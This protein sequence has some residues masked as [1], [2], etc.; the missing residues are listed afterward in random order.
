MFAYTQITQN[1][2]G[3]NN[4]FWCLLHLLRYTTSGCRKLY[5]QACLLLCMVDIDY[6]GA[7]A[8]ESYDEWVA[9]GDYRMST[10]QEARDMIEEI[11]ERFQSSGLL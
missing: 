6:I 3:L 11:I 9:D 8:E 2:H 1:V 4:R 10:L 7:M 5:K